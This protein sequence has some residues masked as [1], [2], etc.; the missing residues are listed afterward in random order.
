MLGDRADEEARSLIRYLRPAFQ[1]PGYT[2]TVTQTLD[3][4]EASTPPPDNVIPWHA[5]LPAQ[6]ASVHSILS[7]SRVP[8]APQD[9]ARAYRGKRAATVRPVLD[10]LA[11]VGLARRTGEGKYAA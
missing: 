1:Q 5:E 6:I 10:A 9:I 11:G 4:G 3:L 7:A 2:A 8:L